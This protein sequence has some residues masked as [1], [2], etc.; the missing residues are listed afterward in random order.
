MSG[1]QISCQTKNWYKINN[2]NTQQNCKCRLRG[3][4]DETV[5][6][7]KHKEY[8]NNNNNTQM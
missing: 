8:N 2:N 3:E 5:I 6:V 7:K 4:W 1:I